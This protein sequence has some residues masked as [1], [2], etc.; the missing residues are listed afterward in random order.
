[1]LF[2]LPGG[3]RKL[4]NLYRGPP[5]IPRFQVEGQGLPLFLMRGD[6]DEEP[7]GVTGTTKPPIGTPPTGKTKPMFLAKLGKSKTATGRLFTEPQQETTTAPVTPERRPLLS[8]PRQIPSTTTAVPLRNAHDSPV[9]DRAGNLVTPQ[10]PRRGRTTSVGP[11][12]PL[13]RQVRSGSVPHQ[14]D[15]PLLPPNTLMSELYARMAELRTP[16]TRQRL[17]FTFDTSVKRM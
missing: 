11:S 13:A 10:S 5:M 16:G 6:S 1:M 2:L 4:S 9:I 3:R 12:S 7:V 17:S 15:A 14:G 8:L